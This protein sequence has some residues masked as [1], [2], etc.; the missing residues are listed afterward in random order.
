[1]RK[2]VLVVIILCANYIQSKAQLSLDHILDSGVLITGG[3]NTIAG[4]QSVSDGKGGAIILFAKQINQDTIF[5]QHISSNGELLWGT[6]INPNIAA[7]KNN[8]ANYSVTP[9]SVISDNKGGVFFTYIESGDLDQNSD[10]FFESYIQHID[11]NGTFLMGVH[12]VKVA[13]KNY[14]AKYATII[15]DGASG[16]IAA[17]LEQAWNPK[18]SRFQS[19]E[20]YL[21]KYSSTGVPQWP[22]GGVQV[23]NAAGLRRNPAITMDGNKGVVIA[24]EDS[25]NC[26]PVDSFYNTDVYAQRLDSNGNL[27]WSASGLPVS[28]KPGNQSPWEAIT[29][30]GN[31]NFSISFSTSDN[32][33]NNTNINVQQ[34][35]Q[36]GVRAWA[37]NGVQLDTLLADGDFQNF[38]I[39]SDGK[40]GVVAF[41]GKYN[42]VPND[43]NEYSFI[44]RIDSASGNLLWPSTKI[45]LLNDPNGYS[46]GND[47]VSDM[48]GNLIFSV[49]PY[50]DTTDYSRVQKVDFTG[51]PQWGTGGKNYWFVADQLVPQPDGSFIALSNERT[52]YDGTYDYSNIA[53]YKI[54]INGIPVW[55]TSSF[56][57]IMDGDWNDPAIWETG[58]VPTEY[59]N[60]M[61]T[62][63]VLI[64][65][66]VVCN[67]LKV[68]PGFNVTLVNGAHLTVLH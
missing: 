41:W 51:N 28:L 54:D 17:W 3:V 35:S 13:I 1:M 63:N 19:S 14:Y 26:T 7:I 5:M 48:A 67:S 45:N 44:Q 23:C 27:K 60:V 59:T 18:K 32:Y 64:S 29:Q 42:R 39:K 65:S 68:S 52:T 16:V 22:N 2:I 62:T 25:R 36:N 11:S 37:A 38:K 21:Q 15:S 6:S 50:N 40:G 24:F 31:Y 61:I 12:G 10:E 46:Y 4:Y 34:L 53:A 9:V 49:W 33:Y 8:P 30:P 58:F 55:R 66:D 43:V 20:I 47:L 56:K 57:T